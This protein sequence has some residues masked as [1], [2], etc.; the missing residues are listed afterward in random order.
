MDFRFTPEQDQ[1]REEVRGI[2]ESLI[3]PE[4]EVEMQDNNDLGPGPAGNEFLRALGEK[5][6]L[7]IPWEEKYGGLG[8]PLMDQYIFSEEIGRIGGLYTNGTAVNMVGPTI[9]RVGT[10]EQ[11]ADWLPKMLSG[12]VECSL[13]YTEP[14]A[15]TDLAGLE[16]RAVEDGDELFIRS[17]V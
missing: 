9:I 5:G 4:L 13:G 15:G 17:G 10:G 6:L 12:D 1:W 8:R 3:T 7:G 2:I 14:G 11:R 16:T